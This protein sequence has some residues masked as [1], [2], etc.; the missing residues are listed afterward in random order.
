[1]KVFDKL[2][3][4]ND[5]TRKHRFIYDEL[6]IVVFKIYLNKEIFRELILDLKHY[7]Y[8]IKDSVVIQH[9]QE[10]ED[11]A[12]ITFDVVTFDEVKKDDKS[13]YERLTIPQ[14]NG[15]CFTKH[16]S[17][18]KN[19][20]G[21]L[22]HLNLVKYFYTTKEEKDKAIMDLDNVKDQNQ[23]K[24]VVLMDVLCKSKESMLIIT[25]PN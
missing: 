2:M 18:E 24:E 11:I 8:A 22:S 5:N 13:F 19:N 15:S 7:F 10:S 12:S 21:D 25:I 3:I 6:F 4:C 9:I 16:V 14:K 17:N 23:N 20:L 1:M